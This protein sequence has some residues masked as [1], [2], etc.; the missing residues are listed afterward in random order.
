MALAVEHITLNATQ[1]S[2]RYVD[3]T[4]TPVD[5]VNV[6]LDTIGGTAQA[7]DGDFGV[8]ATTA[9]PLVRVKWDSA[10]YALYSQLVTNDRIRI[11]YDRS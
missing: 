11:I 4:G 9:S 2:N 6:A 5:V 7:I 10:G 8:D 3:M 1:A